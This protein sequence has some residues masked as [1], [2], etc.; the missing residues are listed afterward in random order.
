MML[1]LLGRDFLLFISLWWAIDLIVTSEAGFLGPLPYSLKWKRLKNSYMCFLEVR[2]LMMWTLH[3]RL[4]INL[5]AFENQRRVI[6][7]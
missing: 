3:Y 2:C 7:Q 1:R 4:Q 6:Q 5:L